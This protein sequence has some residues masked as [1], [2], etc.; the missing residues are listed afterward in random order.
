MAKALLIAAAL[1]A[2]AGTAALIFT[3]ASVIRYGADPLSEVMVFAV[4]VMWIGII[5]SV[6][7]GLP[8][9]FLFR[10]LGWNQLWQ[11]SMVGAFIGLLSAYVFGMMF[12]AV[13][14]SVSGATGAL[15]FWLIAGRTSRA[16]EN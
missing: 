5:I 7:I 10:Y 11:Y 9:Y 16:I 3:V 2:A 4:I 8:V 12:E 6:L 14:I 13:E 15:V 1:I